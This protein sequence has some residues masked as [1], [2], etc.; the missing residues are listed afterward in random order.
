[1]NLKINF[2]P[3]KK[4]RLLYIN[5]LKKENQMALNHSRSYSLYSFDLLVTIL[6]IVL[7]SNVK[8]GKHEV[9]YRHDILEVFKENKMSHF[10][11]ERSNF[12][13]GQFL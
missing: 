10:T 1:M 5:H 9:L 13:N 8:C 3:L 7:G 12:A 6:Q 4:I 11:I 2:R